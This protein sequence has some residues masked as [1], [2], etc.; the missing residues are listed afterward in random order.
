M[1][2]ICEE[3]E[4]GWSHEVSQPKLKTKRAVTDSYINYRWGGD[5]DAQI[6]ALVNT[7][8]ASGEVVVFLLN[9]ALN[10]YQAGR[11]RLK[12]EIIVLLQKESSTW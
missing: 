9:Y 5:I 8:L 12:I 11:L 6:K 7:S 4:D 10:A 1:T 3:A 2:L